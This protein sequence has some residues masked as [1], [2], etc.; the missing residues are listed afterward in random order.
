LT[1]NGE[2]AEFGSDGSFNKRLLI[3]EGENQITVTAK[4]L[5]ENETSVTRSVY[6]DTALPKLENISPAEDVRITPGQPVR[7]SFDSASGLEASFHVELPFNLSTLG[8][9]DIPLNETSSGHYEGTYFTSSSLNLEGGV[10]VIR[11]RDAAGN[12]VETEAP[13]R[14]YVANGGGQNPDPNPSNE[15]PVAIIQANE[16][17]KKNKNVQFNAKASRDVDGEIVSYSWNFGDGDTAVG[18]KVKHKFTTAG[19][20]TVE[21]TVTDNDGASGKTVHTITIR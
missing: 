3:N 8:R 6:V 1:I 15:K 20:Y 19:T 18:S 2:P 14:L 21:L 9:N 17:A 7:V 5:A 12:E 4:D 11:V 10:I 13:G 16:S